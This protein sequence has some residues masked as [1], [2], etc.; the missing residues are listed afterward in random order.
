MLLADDLAVRR[1]SDHSL[2]GAIAVLGIGD[3]RAPTGGAVLARVT[4]LLDPPR[5]LPVAGR[6]GGVGAAVTLL[7]VPAMV[8]PTVCPLVFV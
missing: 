3:R 7:L 1:G 5:P 8:A 2:A 4:R 6:F